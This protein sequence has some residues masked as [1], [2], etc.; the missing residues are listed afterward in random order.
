M[1]LNL[2]QLDFSKLLPL[3][4]NMTEEQKQDFIIRFAEATARGT[5]EGAARGAKC[6]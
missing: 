5:A 1:D 2:G 4:R 6:K 3:M